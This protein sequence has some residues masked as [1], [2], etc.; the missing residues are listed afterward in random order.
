[1]LTGWLSTSNHLNFASFTLKIIENVKLVRDPS[2]SRICFQR[3]ID[4]SNT[5]TE[6]NIWLWNKTMGKC[7]DTLELEYSHRKFCVY[8]IFGNSNLCLKVIEKLSFS[9]QRYLSAIMLVRY[10]VLWINRNV[11]N[12]QIEHSRTLLLW[13][14]LSFLKYRMVKQKQLV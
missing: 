12:N 8:I 11:Y 7:N 13:S 5:N 10:V 1:M 9:L 4:K 3:Q 2:S 6:Y 14:V